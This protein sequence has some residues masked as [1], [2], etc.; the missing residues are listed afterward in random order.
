MS[1]LTKD[2]DDYRPEKDT[3]KEPRNYS[4]C[5]QRK[6]F[7]KET[8]SMSNY[9]TNTKVAKHTCMKHDSATNG[10][11]RNKQPHT[12]DSTHGIQFW[13]MA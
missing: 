4:G 12:K 9:K 10:N 1:N 2:T 13:L 5:L 3:D 8:I 11:Y 6:F 7:H